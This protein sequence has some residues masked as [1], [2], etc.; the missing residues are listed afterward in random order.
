MLVSRPLWALYANGLLGRQA[1]TTVKWRGGGGEADCVCVCVPVWTSCQKTSN[2]TDCCLMT[3][4]TLAHTFSTVTGSTHT[5]THTDKPTDAGLHYVAEFLQHLHIRTYC[6][7]RACVCAWHGEERIVF[8]SSP[9]LSLP[10]ILA[11]VCVCV[12]V[13][14]QLDDPF[15][16]EQ[17][18]YLAVGA[19]LGAAHRQDI[20]F[21]LSLSLPLALCVSVFMCVHYHVGDASGFIGMW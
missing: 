19:P 15:A 9:P 3:G 14:W 7:R 4:K 2:G 21:Y 5:H 17:L 1:T 10:H 8:S 11:C 12:C 20:Y 13:P 16:L 6:L 18:A